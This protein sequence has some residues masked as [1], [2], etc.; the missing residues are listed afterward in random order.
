MIKNYILK[1]SFLIMFVGFT[2]QLKA[3][4]ARIDQLQTKLES[5][6]IDAPGLSQKAE[7]NV[8]D[9]TLS[10]FLQALATAHKLNLN[11]HPELNDIN[12]R[13]NFSNATVSDVLIFLCKEYDLDIDFTGNI[14]SIHKLEK[15]VPIV[16]QREIP[17]NYNI[18]ADIFSVDLRRDTLYLAF[19]QIMDKT[20]KNLVFAPGME[21]LLI[22]SYIK[23][24]PFDNALDKIAF[25]NN[26]S[27]TKTRDNF[28]LFEQNDILQITAIPN[29]NK[30]NSTG[31]EPERPQQSQRP[32]R[33]RRSNFFFEVTDTI[34]QI[35]NVEFDNTPISN[36]I[37]DIGHE[38]NKN[39]F[40]AAPLNEAGNA[41]VKADFI[42][43]DLLLDRILENTDFTYKKRDSIYYFGKKEQISLR[44]AVVIPLMHRS[45]EVMTNNTST[46][47]RAGR[48]TS[49]YSQ[50]S[51]YSNYNNSSNY[52]N[53][54]SSSNVNSLN[55]SN[56][57]NIN[58]NRTESFSE[59][60]NQVES[61]INMLPE[62]VVKDLKV[63]VDVE[64]NSFIV[65][66]PSQNIKRFKE[67]ITYIDKPVPVILIEVMLLEVN[68]SATI[69][70]GISWGIGAEPTTT[71]GDIYPNADVNLGAS[72][73]N[74]IIG[75]F[76]GFGSLNL[77]Q[78]VPNFFANI[79]AMETNGDIKIR[80]S[81]RLSALNG[82][83]AN[84][85]I[86]E[87]TYY[88][89]TQ[90]DIIGSLNPQISDVTNYQPIDAEFAINIKPLVSGD[91]QI[92][93]DIN[94][95]QSTFNSNKVA[96]DAPPGINSREFNSIIRVKDQDLV[97]LG[98][99][100]EKIK[101]D[102]GNGVPFLARIP[103]IKWF[104]SKKKREDTKKK[105]TVLIK[106]TIIK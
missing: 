47:R 15:E 6:I 14:F 87:T 73:I 65:S 38:L 9:V 106:P 101:N 84:L 79:K 30:S 20:G 40:T 45:I 67:F 11:I 62:D 22:S 90:R 77:G 12:I 55:N 54:G 78:V 28:Y 23:S 49:S 21:R 52:I 1:F 75:G 76:S 105:L 48:S 86:G 51:G 3:Q 99:L 81:P 91:G 56:L 80:S 59:R 98:G 5:I 32:Q 31:K 94:V 17:I 70:T 24:M 8:N 43:Y 102:S 82:H 64:L 103:V 66:G 83:R 57:Q 61:L 44:D 93:L 27:V 96:D 42:T 63:M 58:T 60:D 71:Q 35:M 18:N 16:K 100:E 13:N 4:N 85:S 41:T 19:K 72:T 46:E 92:T 53:T 36:V 68:K 33:Q 10:D 97:I 104:F 69:E 50:N 37:Y 74:R 29:Q 7:I 89:V 25:A 88:A 2:L 39:M 95:I 34:S 26:L